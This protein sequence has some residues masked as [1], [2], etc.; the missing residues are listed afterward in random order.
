MFSLL[1]FFPSFLHSSPPPTNKLQKHGLETHVLLP[2]T[3]SLPPNGKVSTAAIPGAEEVVYSRQCCTACIGDRPQCRR[4]LQTGLAERSSGLH[5]GPPCHGCCL[6]LGCARNLKLQGSSGHGSKAAGRWM[7]LRSAVQ[8]EGHCHSGTE[9]H[10]GGPR[11]LEGYS[12]S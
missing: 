1:F 9:V 8:N 6:F 11:H 3:S 10:G 2:S 12:H 7:P 4:L 5:C